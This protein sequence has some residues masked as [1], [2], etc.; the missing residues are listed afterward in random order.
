MC[1]IILSQK[2]M[3]L[4]F[5]NLGPK[6]FDEFEELFNDL[7][8]KTFDHLSVKDNYIIDV[9][10]TDN[11]QIHKINR[12]YRNIDR[13]TD[14][15]SFAFLD[16]KDEVLVGDDM[17]RSLG[18]IIVSYE[19]AEAQAKEYGHSLKREMS[20]LFVH[21][22]LH[23]LGY[24]HMKEEDEKVMFKIQDEILGGRFDG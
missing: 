3:E 14:V 1:A 16:D 9:V 19:K 21:G 22:L 8:K 11:E 2:I 15:I 13:E 23:L 4:D 20:F 7:V 5:E 24:D 10:I 6:L 17:P 18:Q 12:E